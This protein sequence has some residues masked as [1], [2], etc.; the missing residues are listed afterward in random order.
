MHQDYCGKSTW[1]PWLFIGIVSSGL[2][3][4]SNQVLTSYCEA[5]MW[6]RMNKPQR[7]AGVTSKQWSNYHHRRHCSSLHVIGCIRSRGEHRK[8]RD[9]RGRGN[10]E[11]QDASKESR[12]GVELSTVPIRLLLLLKLVRGTQ[13]CGSKIQ[14]E[15]WWQELCQRRLPSAP[16]IFQPTKQVWGQKWVVCTFK[17]SKYFARYLA[18]FSKEICMYVCVWYKVICSWL[19]YSLALWGARHPPP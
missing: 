16:A 8:G 11:S 7:S 10:V 2:L 3:L 1:S 9:G 4:P 12:K 18:L 13:L 19:F 15:F 14:R 6:E 17:P 5:G